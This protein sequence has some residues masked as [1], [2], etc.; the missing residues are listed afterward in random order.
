MAAEPSRAAANLTIWTARLVGGA[1]L[2]AFGVFVLRGP[3]DL[4]DLGLAISG[5]LVVDA[6]LSLFFFLQH[7]GM[8]RRSFRRRLERVVVPAYGGAVYT[9]ASSS[10]LLL[11]VLLWQPAGAELLELRGA[12]RFAAHAVFGAGLLGLLSG[13]LALGEFDVFGVVPILARLRGRPERRVPLVVRGA[14]RWVRH[15]L[16]T[17]ILLLIWGVPD[18]T[19]D[20]LLF[21]VLWTAWIVVGA[22]LEERDLVEAHGERYVDYQRAVPMLIPWRAPRG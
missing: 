14:Y 3:F 17:S 21:A 12:W 18:W 2:L 6:V 5:A 19:A 9:F 10:A 1:S 4:V 11:V 13:V 7:S 20:R 8:V 15:P 16:Y 22:I